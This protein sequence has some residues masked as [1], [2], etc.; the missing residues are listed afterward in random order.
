MPD[1]EFPEYAISYSTNARSSRDSLS[2]KLREELI[3][4]E[5]ELALNPDKFP[6]RT[7]Q[8]EGNIFIYKHPQPTIEITYRI[9]RDRKVLFFLHVVS[10][11]L[12]VSKTLFIS[13]SHEDKEWLLELKKW[14]KPLEKRDLVSVWD[15]QMIKAG[16]DWK[17]EIEKALA[18]AKAAVLLISIDFLNSEF[19]SSN[20][21]PQLL[22]AAKEKGL[23]IF[24][25][26]VRPSMVDE[27]EIIKFQAAHK[28]PP[29]AELSAKEREA[30]FLR[31]YRQL[32]EV[33]EA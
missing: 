2:A 14:L 20:E 27:T 4:I 18:S 5:D 25:I 19:I 11:A 24:W 8:L 17:K 15:D 22:N 30:H 6:G 26:A 31:I 9:D 1:I 16:D 10:I 21:L 28:E 7:I 12:D 3:H 29:L 32:K 23:K 13:Y 33:V